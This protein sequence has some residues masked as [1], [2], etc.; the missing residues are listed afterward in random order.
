MYAIRSYY[1]KGDFNLALSNDAAQAGVTATF[2]CEVPALNTY[3][4][5][6]VNGWY[7]HQN[8]ISLLPKGVIV[9]SLLEKAKENPALFEKYYGTRT[10]I[11]SDGLA[12]MNTAF[13][14]DGAFVYIPKGVVV[15]KP[16]QIVNIMTGDSDR[17]VFQRN[18]IIADENSQ[19][20]VMLCEHTLSTQKYVINTVTELFANEHSILDMYNIQNQHNFTTQVAG[21]YASQKT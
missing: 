19:L 13:A 15:D 2:N 12:A 7:S 11:G 6:M 8:D 18:L 20:K 16:I 10:P 5:F 3:N 17:L 4:I 21:Y 1:V 14:Q 9:G